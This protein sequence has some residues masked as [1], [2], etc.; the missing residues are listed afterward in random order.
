VHTW[1][2]EGRYCKHDAEEPGPTN[3]DSFLTSGWKFRRQKE[4]CSS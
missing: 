2:A 4:R 3:D 1:G